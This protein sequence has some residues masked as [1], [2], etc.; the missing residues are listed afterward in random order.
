MNMTTRF[1][2]QLLHNC[3]KALNALTQEALADADAFEALEPRTLMSISL[4]VKAEPP[5][6]APAALV[7]HTLSPT[8]VQL[9]WAAAPNAVDGFYIMRSDGAGAY[10]QIAKLT[11][12]NARSFIDTSVLSNHSYHY[13]IAA[14]KGTARS[15][16]SNIVAKFTPLYT[17]TTFIAATLSSSGVR[18]SWK[19]GDADTR[20]YV[21]MRSTD[22]KNFSTIS[23]ISSSTATSY[24]DSAVVSGTIYAYR[25]QATAGANISTFTAT[26]R[27]AVALRAPT[28]VQAATTPTSVTISWGGLDKSATSYLVMRSTDGATFTTIATLGSTASTYT[29][30]TVT[31][32]TSYTY[33]VQS[34]SA[35]APAGTSATVIASTGL[36]APRSINATLSGSDVRL[37]WSDANKPGMGYI[38]LRSLDNVHFTRIATLAQGASRAFTDSTADAGRW[39]AYRIQAAYGT[40]VS[41]ASASVVIKT[42]P[43][44]ST[45][46]IS[47]RYDGELI[48]TA[49]GS[50]DTIT[51]SQAG[52]MLTISAGGRTYTS[53]SAPG[54]LFIYD[55]GGANTITID[56]SVTVRTTITGLGGSLTTVRTLAQNVSAWLDSTDIFSGPG[57]LHSIASFAGGVSKAIGASL[58]NPKDSG[59]TTKVDGS[60]WGRGPTM[61]DVNQGGVGDCYFLASVAAFANEAP[62]LLMES[63][64]DLGDGTYAVQFIQDDGPVFVRVST[65]VP[66]GYFSGYAYAQPGA[67]GAVWAPIMEKAVAYFRTGANSYASIASGWMGEVYSALGVKSSDFIIAS[68]ESGFTSGLIA[69]LAAGRAVT[70]ATSLSAKTLVGNHAYTLVSIASGSSGGTLFTLR[71]PWGVSG[72][73]AENSDGFV[74][75]TFAQLKANVVAGTRAA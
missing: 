53:L 17:P 22:G 69:D 5:P 35:M 29:D 30:T 61:D 32:A 8:T 50:S 57:I 27:A 51:V 33:R 15:G 10:Q 55:H 19:A 28:N 23:T 59:E 11:T 67:S 31:S 43:S 21:L 39:Y 54:G 42:A 66:S 4:V 34:R 58:A 62:E 73:S 47:T 38:V 44:V 75:L 74:T 20:G 63:A 13:E 41:E 45:V 6:A 71:N 68:S 2:T 9:D 49:S 52:S 36:L 16:Y 25:L 37:T 7:A 40:K 18:L 46:E 14:Y 48:V 56:S 26:I 1:T 60:L 24:I 65:A 12:G 3:G 72:T 70:L 64:V